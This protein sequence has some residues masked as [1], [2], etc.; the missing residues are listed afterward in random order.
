MIRLDGR[1]RRF[2]DVD[3]FL[4]GADFD[5]TFF[6]STVFFAT[7]FFRMVF[8]AAAFFAMGFFAIGFFEG[9]FFVMVFFLGLVRAALTGVPDSFFAAFWEAR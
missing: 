8:L 9:A 1:H 5:V 6:F 3:D 2:E 7:D 4:R